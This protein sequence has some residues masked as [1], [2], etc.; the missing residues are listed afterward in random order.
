MKKLVFFFCLSVFSLQTIAQTKPQALKFDEFDD[1]MET[2]YW[3][4]EFPMT[5]SQRLE[6]FIKQLKTERN[7]LVY[8][9]YY[10]ARKIDDIDKNSISNW[11]DMSKNHISYETKIREEN[12]FVINGGLRERNSLEYWIVPK[13]AQPPKPAPL[14][15]DS[16]GI[17]CPRVSIASDR[18]YFNSDHT[19]TFTAYPEDLIKKYGLT[20]KVSA[21]KISIGQGS[22]KINVD[23]GNVTAGHVNAFLELSNF[24][25]SCKNVAMTTLDISGQTYLFDSFSSYYQSQMRAIM[26]GFLIEIQNHPELKGY[27][28]SYG[29]RKRPQSLAAGVKFF[30]D[31]IKFRRFDSTRIS[32]VEGGYRDNIAAELYLMPPDGETPVSKPTVNKKFILEKHRTKK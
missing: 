22:G 10:R 26:D 23:L 12:I 18:E 20:W 27:I 2:G 11:A 3:S 29:E 30:K 6:R 19:V 8:V 24:P 5:M 1:Q 31:H 32:I 9:I 4:E 16:E 17:V 13:G 14:Y 7:T 28:I 15:D 25:Y 21:G